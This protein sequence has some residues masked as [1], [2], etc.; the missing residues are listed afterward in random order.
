MSATAPGRVI[1]FYS[2][3]GGSGRSMVLAHMAW[4]LAAAG[5]KV[6]AIDWD[7]E[8]P[9]LHRFF[10]PF[11]EDKDL[12]FSEGMIDCVVNYSAAALAPPVVV[13]GQAPPAP[14]YVPYA[15]LLQYASSL[16]WEGF[17][18]PGTLDFVPA[19]KQD[20]HYAE[21]VN[22]FN[23]QHFYDVLSGV[24]FLEEMKLQTQREYDFILID[25]R[26]GVSD[27]SGTCTVQMPDDLVVC[28]TMNTQ[29]IDGAAHMATA[30][31]MQRRK[32]RGGSTLR[33]WPVAMRIDAADPAKV[34]Y[35]RKRAMDRFDSLLTHLAAPQREQ[36]WQRIAIPYDTVFGYDEVMAPSLPAGGTGSTFVT[37]VESLTSYFLDGAPARETQAPAAPAGEPRSEQPDA[38]G[39]QLRSDQEP[40]AFLSYAHFDDRNEYITRF[41][42]LLSEEVQ[43]QTGK[44]FQ[45]FQDRKSLEW[46]AN[47]PRRLEESLN[48]V[49]FLIVVCTPSYFNS[50]DCRDELQRFLERERDLRRDDLV[51]GVYLVETPGL[52]ELRNEHADDLVRTVST[53]QLADWTGLQR[54]SLTSKK[55]GEE[56]AKLARKIQQRLKPK[57]P[58]RP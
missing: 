21:R 14:W 19:G 12:E 40:G 51:L 15:D 39:V 30:A 31:Y 56:I 25:S 17:P 5:K 29:S 54:R 58:G 57:P 26:T 47:W 41:R 8:A 42:E 53:R 13:A 9:G 50:P 7:L 55:M 48:E 36:Y 46:G 11:M 20:A 1:T 22:L 44:T 23:W 10:G 3:K 35:L 34:L 37:S 49:T 2:Y 18:R 6:L 38:A 27:T 32:P 16:T 28:F 52:G 24:A 45:I 4:M 33:V 43:A